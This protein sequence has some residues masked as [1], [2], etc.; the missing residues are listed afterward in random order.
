[1]TISL[2]HFAETIF[3]AMV[4]EHREA[5][6]SLCKLADVA[7]LKYVRTVKTLA[8]CEAKLEPYGGKA[9]DGASRVDVVVRLRKDHAAAFELKLGLTRL[10]EKRVDEWMQQCQ[11]S[12][13]GRRWRGNMMAILERRFPKPMAGEL[14]AIVGEEQLRLERDWFVVAR[15]VILQPWK[16]N[17]VLSKA[18]SHIKSLAFEDVVE[19]FGGK[20]AF[21]DLIR[22]MLEIDFYD[23]WISKFAEEAFPS[24]ATPSL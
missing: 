8:S 13:E 23:E 14:T 24:T 4:N 5:F 12:H 17:D 21:N 15:R 19:N 3:A 22:R 18:S 2:T 6:L 9:F 10:N 7:D 16:D 20:E 11:T 1:M